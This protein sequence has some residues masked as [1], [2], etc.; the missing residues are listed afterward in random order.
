MRTLEDA[1]ALHRVGRIL[2]DVSACAR[3]CWRPTFIGAWA[4]SDERLPTWQHAFADPRAQEAT[5]V[6][7]APAARSRRLSKPT[8]SKRTT[9][10][11]WRARSFLISMR[12]WASAIP[13]RRR[14]PEPRSEY[15]Q[16]ACDAFELIRRDG[17][18]LEA[19]DA[20]RP[21]RQRFARRARPRPGRT[22]VASCASRA[23][24]TSPRKARSGTCSTAGRRTR[25]AKAS[26]C[27]WGKRLARCFPNIWIAWSPPTSRK[28]NHSS[29]ISSRAHGCKEAVN[30]LLA[31]RELS[32]VHVG[33]RSL[34]QVAP[35]RAILPKRE[36][37][38]I[39]R[40]LRDLIAPSTRT[41]NAG[42]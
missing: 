32:F 34:V 31:A 41:A 29:A 26:V 16:L 1:R 22:V 40:P 18:D 3:R 4:G 7:G 27:R 5:G 17:P 6:D 33:G 11:W 42:N 2:P 13:S 20:R 24:T 36:R 30:A 19:E 25:C 10:S 14:K 28:W 23:W 12:W 21:G 39:I 37:T 38:Q 9:P 8:C 35:P 15:S